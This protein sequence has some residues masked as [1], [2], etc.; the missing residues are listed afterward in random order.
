MQELSSEKLLKF[1]V[2]NFQISQVGAR[3]STVSSMEQLT[4]PSKTREEASGKKC[5]IETLSN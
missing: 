2:K 1:K 4:L 5:S 3:R